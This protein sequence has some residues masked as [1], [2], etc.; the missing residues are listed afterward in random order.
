[1]NIGMIGLAV[2][3]SNLALNMA[4]HG[5]K[6]A[7]W[8][9]TPDL[10]EKFAAEHPHDNIKCFLEL[11]DFV[12]AIDRPRKI[13]FMIMAGAPVDSMIETLTP[14]LDE[15]DIILDG[16]NS[17][18]EDTVRRHDLL[19]SR[20]IHY[21]GV[22]ISGGESG[23]RF[24]PC[25][26]PGGD[27]NAYE[28]VRPIFEAIAARA[29]DG[30][31]CCAY[32]GNDGAGHYVKMVHNGIEY[33][34]MQLIAE[35]YL[36][37]KTIGGLDNA[38]ISKTFAKWNED[39]LESFLIK[40]TADIFA[41]DDPDGEGQ[42]IDKIVDIAGQKGTGR[43]TSL[44]A[45]NQGVNVSIMTA[46][47]NARV[48]SNRTIERLEFPP[49]HPIKPIAFKTPP[50]VLLEQ[51]NEDM[52]EQAED[53]SDELT[54]KSPDTRQGR[55]PTGDNFIADVRRALYIGKI[56]AYS[57]GFAL[58]RSASELYNWNLDLGKIASIF[59]AGCIIQA[60]F[61]E[62]ITDAYKKNPKLENLILDEFFFQKIKY[63]LQ[64][65]RRTIS[66]AVFN[67]IPVPA[68]ANALE[69][70]DQLR[71]ERLGANLIQ[72]Q[73]DY[74]GAHTFKRIDRE[75]SFHHDWQK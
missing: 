47:C 50:T 69:Y 14:L 60:R 48:M 7:A 36:M 51:S 8:N 30:S 58:Y 2:M 39:A 21:F 44:A 61:L 33:A 72:A 65:L 15:G 55:I 57:Q 3:G 5:F 20:G 75:G 41:E 35:T 43:W 70:I 6:V 40:I 73:R 32:I 71:A 34:D 46:A 74:F 45:L 59:R 23:A 31:P 24:G 26:M 12:Q 4:D 63:G 27:R 67:G 1:M 28:T 68:L 64:S 18:F 17:F 62:H 37:L 13:M 16:G 11:K 49:T 22:G 52:S 19:K 56:A 38:M 54:V 29:N 25:I 42:L 10:T 53:S 9:Y 66:R